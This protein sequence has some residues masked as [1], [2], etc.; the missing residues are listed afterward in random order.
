MNNLDLTPLEQR[1][2]QRSSDLA[3]TRRR[4]TIVVISGITAATLLAVIALVD[5]SWQFVLSV[6]LL[7]IA[8]TVFEKV[9]YANAVLAYKSLIQKLEKHVEELQSD[10]SHR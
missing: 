9:A 6:S 1:I 4:R 2:L 8:G 5:R 3:I 10:V 7:Y